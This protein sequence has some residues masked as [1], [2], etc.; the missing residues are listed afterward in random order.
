MA[1]EVTNTMQSLTFISMYLDLIVQ[2]I[3]GMAESFPQSL[4]TI[5]IKILQT[6]VKRLFEVLT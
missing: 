2:R 1:F 4:A 3:L 5:I 6:S